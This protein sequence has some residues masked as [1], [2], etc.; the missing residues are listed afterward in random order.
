MEK[1]MKNWAENAFGHVKYLS[2]YV[3]KTNVRHKIIEYIRITN[4]I[5]EFQG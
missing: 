1:L 5:P 4:N 3:L 2:K